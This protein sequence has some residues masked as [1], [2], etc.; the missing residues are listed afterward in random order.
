M[1]WTPHSLSLS[2]NSEK[3]KEKYIR[4]STN[5]ERDR[6]YIYELD[7]SVR[8]MTSKGEANIEMR[9]ATL[10]YPTRVIRVGWSKNTE[11]T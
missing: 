11:L 2:P 10:K 8:T 5:L 9:D 7:R 3:E 4:F 6:S 1:A